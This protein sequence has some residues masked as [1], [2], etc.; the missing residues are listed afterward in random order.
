V[1]GVYV[2]VER[3]VERDWTWVVNREMYI[4]GERRWEVSLEHRVYSA[5]ELKAL[6]RAEGF[7]EVRICGDLTGA[8][9]DT[10]AKRLIAVATG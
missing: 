1:D 4:D 9:Y 5:A 7:G 10:E 6:L 2:V 3:T 8:A